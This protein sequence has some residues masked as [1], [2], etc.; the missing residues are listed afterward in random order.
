MSSNP[1][2]AYL[3]TQVL[4]AS[5]LQLVRLAYDGIMQSIADA[6][7]HLAGGRIR[8]RSQAITKALDLLTELVRGIDFERGGELSLQ[9]ARLY[10]YMQRRLIEA[11]ARQMD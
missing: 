6:R 9:L 8:E 1:Y 10:D 2:S 4:T 7:Q 5:P 11:N 3:E